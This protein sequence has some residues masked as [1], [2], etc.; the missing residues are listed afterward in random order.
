ML[1]R[2]AIFDDIEPVMAIV[3]E[4][5]EEMAEYGNDQWDLSY[6]NE[7][8]FLKDIENETLF[9]AE[10]AGVIM[11]FVTVDQDEPEGYRGLPWSHAGA[12]LVIHRFA[13]ARHSRNRG[14]ASVLEEAVGRMAS[15]R[16]ISLLKVDTHSTNTVMQS[17]LTKKGYQKVGEMEFLRRSRPFFCYEKRV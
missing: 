8:R 17:F 12:C 14:V 9:V 1:V 4:T 16:N 11:G 10:E 15:D 7:A 6:P 3:R 2:R 5:V 13:V